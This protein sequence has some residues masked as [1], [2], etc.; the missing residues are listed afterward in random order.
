MI[1]SR[2]SPESARAIETICCAA[3]RSAPTFARA[4]DRL[5]PEPR[6]ERRGV[7]VH[8]V[9]VEQR[10]APRLVRQEDALGDAQVGD[11]VELL[12]DRR[13]AA[14]ERSRGIAR[15]ERLALEEDLAAGR[16]RPRPRRT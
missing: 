7:A 2:T 15:G 4:W 6:E 10:A 5:V 16:A 8:P 3:G 12:V 11:Q 1:S 14:L 13:D 9:E